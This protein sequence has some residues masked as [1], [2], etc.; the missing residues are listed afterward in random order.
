MISIE[1]HNLE[2]QIREAL[3]LARERGEMVDIL[4]GGTVVAR[5]MPIP[6]LPAKRPDAEVWAAMDRLA[7]EISAYWPEGVSAVDAVREVR[8]EL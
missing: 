1:I 8:R 4:E 2:S 7:E 6:N 3:R 5:L